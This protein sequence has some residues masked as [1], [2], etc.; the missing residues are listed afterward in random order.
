MYS[1]VDAIQL[2]VRRPVGKARLDLDKAERSIEN[3]ERALAIAEERLRNAR[4]RAADARAR[5]ED[6]M[7]H[8]N[9]LLMEM[10]QAGSPVSL[11]PEGSLVSL[12]P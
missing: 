5:L 8:A 6:T 1:E 9:A 3:A 7:Q 2:D 11:I 4:Q 12:I 10:Y